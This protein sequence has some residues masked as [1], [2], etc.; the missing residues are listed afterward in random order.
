M[1]DEPFNVNES[2]THGVNINTIDYDILLNS[3]QT[4]IKAHFWDFGGQEIMHASHQFFLSE[5]SLYILVLDSRKDEKTEYWLKHIES[6]GG[7]SRVII[8]INKI[9]ENPSFDLDRNTLMQKYKNILGFY[10]VSCKNGTGLDEFKKALTDAIPQI[11]LLQTPVAESW[12]NVKEKLEIA[13]AEKNYIDQREFDAICKEEGINDES[14]RTTLIRLLNELGIVLHFEKL[15]LKNY[16]VLNPRWVTEAVYKI[17]NSPC[18]ADQ[19]GIL[20]PKQLAFVL[21]EEKEKTCDYDQQL[22]H[23]SFKPH[24]QSYIISLMDRF[25]LC[26]PLPDDK[27]LIPDL[28]E[29][30]TPGFRLDEPD[31]LRYIVQY[32]FLPRSIISRFIV[33]MHKDIKDELRWRTGVV[34]EDTEL[35]TI[36]IVQSD[37]ADKTISIRVAGKQKRPISPISGEPSA[38]L[39]IHLKNSEHE[40]SFLCPKVRNMS[41]TVN[42][43][44]SN[45][46]GRRNISMENFKGHTPFNIY[47]TASRANR[48][49]GRNINDLK[50]IKKYGSKEI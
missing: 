26:Y 16:Y 48:N 21:N 50:Q 41:N 40:N 36:A 44:G 23:I 24:E 39:T 5:R 37:E 22:K 12:L 11:E 15:G 43:S 32:D 8:V 7:N 1:K 18:L 4:I 3:K 28:L 10:R 30:K 9:D 46:C 2:Q 49:D 45:K 19:K 6:F 27:I 13:S 31:A 20:N 34:L 38:T 42:S 29:K 47:W 33:R 25:E 14:T 35:Q 17:I